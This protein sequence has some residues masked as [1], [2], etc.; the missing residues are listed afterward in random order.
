MFKLLSFYSDTDVEMS[1]F[2]DGLVNDGLLQS[3][4]FV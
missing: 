4:D 3:C 2:V 1:S